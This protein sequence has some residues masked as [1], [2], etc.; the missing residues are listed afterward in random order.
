MELPNGLLQNGP[1][2]VALVDGWGVE[3]PNGTPVEGVTPLDAVVYGSG[4]ETDVGL[5]SLLNP[6]Q[7]AVDL[8]L[9]HI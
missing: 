6:G 8:S 3:L 1:D 9:I 5:L 7:T 4:D 2:A